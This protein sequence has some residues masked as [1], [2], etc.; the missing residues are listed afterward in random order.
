MTADYTTWLNDVHSELDS[1]NMRTDTWQKAWPFDF[2]EEYRKGTAAN[3]A[4]EKANR[5]WW[6]EQ[7][8]SIS[9]DCLKTPDCWL[10]RKHRGE[11]QPVNG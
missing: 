5:Y 6:H 9:Q 10:P 4:A 2:E 8:K 3:V 7:N 1:M 11:C